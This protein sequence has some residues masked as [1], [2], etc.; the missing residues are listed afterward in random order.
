MIAV[1]IASPKGL[2]RFVISTLCLLVLCNLNA[3]LGR[4]FALWAFKYTH[5]RR[6]NFKTK[7]NGSFH[8]AS[9]QGQQHSG[10]RILICCVPLTDVTGHFHIPPLYYF[11]LDFCHTVRWAPVLSIVTCFRQHIMGIRAS[12]LILPFDFSLIWNHLLWWV[13][14]AEQSKLIRLP[15]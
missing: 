13:H 1:I 3:L 8:H 12:T 11:L 2:M 14:T 15:H 5:M 6:M 9:R 7:G 10:Q 4:P